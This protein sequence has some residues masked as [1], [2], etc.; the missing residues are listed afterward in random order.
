MPTAVS[1]Y[2]PNIVFGGDILEVFK[3]IDEAQPFP[4]EH[5][6]FTIAENDTN[7]E[8]AF[9]GIKIWSDINP[10]EYFVPSGLYTQSLTIDDVPCS[11][12]AIMIYN[13]LLCDPGVKG[14]ET[15]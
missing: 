12:V 8:Q 13:M 4:P 1:A 10:E 15:A 14:K 3:Q 7:I 11:Q 6:E 2:K 5:W 9:E